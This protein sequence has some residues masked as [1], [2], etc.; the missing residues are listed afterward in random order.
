MRQLSEFEFEYILTDLELKGVTEQ[1]IR[2]ELA[3]HIG[4]LVEENP[5]LDTNFKG[6]Y[7]MV[8]DTFKLDRLGNLQHKILLSEN[9]K[10]QAMKK[11]TYILGALSAI[12][13]VTGA[14]FKTY[15]LP[16]AGVAILLASVLIVFAFLPTLFYTSYKED[17]SKLSMALSAIGFT[18]AAA[19]LLGL[20]FKIMHWPGAKIMLIFG[21][22]AL[23][24]GFFPAYVLSIFRNAPNRQ[25]V[26]MVILL[27]V[28]A[29]SVLLM[30]SSISYSY[31]VKENY[32]N[33][34]KTA[35]VVSKLI[36][37]DTE[38]ITDTAAVS[39]IGEIKS[40][41]NELIA[42]LELARMKLLHEIGDSLTIDS[43]RLESDRATN[44]VML[45]QGFGNQITDAVSRYNEVLKAYAQTQR[46]SMI[47]E[48]Y[49]TGLPRLV[50]TPVL[51]SLIDIAEI[52]RNVRMVEYDI[53]MELS[54]ARN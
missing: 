8:V 39:A 14:L 33:R 47:I 18:V 24:V 31:D 11:S 44:R 45:S 13:M 28:I 48:S 52:E 23:V 49:L 34:Y 40:Q 1:H 46:T 54:S 5:L 30:R 2:L 19:M 7:N 20:L 6:A 32:I 12:L 29:A 10:F 37:Q 22:V 50:H 16:G 53:L 43:R 26:P 42:L 51:I 41:S 36:A 35:L 25:K 9:L 3:D 27:I 21:Q 17:P 15:H 38:T 4:C